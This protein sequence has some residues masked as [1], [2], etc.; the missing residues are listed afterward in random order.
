MDAVRIQ[1]DKA[2]NSTINQGNA[3]TDVGKSKLTRK[4]FRPLYGL[5]FLSRQ[6]VDHLS[7][8]VIFNP[9]LIHKLPE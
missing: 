1:S 9:C 3:H 7:K 8:I 5:K 2:C 4:N 6:D